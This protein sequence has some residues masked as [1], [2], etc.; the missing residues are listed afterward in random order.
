MGAICGDC[1][2]SMHSGPPAMP[3]GPALPNGTG[4]I[5]SR[6]QIHDWADERLW[7]GLTTPSDESWLAG[8]DALSRLPLDEASGSSAYKQRFLHVQSLGQRARQ[9]T[10][11]EDRSKLYAELLGMCASCHVSAGV[12]VVDRPS[13]SWLGP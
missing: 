3:V 2:R 6:M 11:A 7:E 5:T 8:A 9:L 12:R 4:N 10:T 1:H 13:L